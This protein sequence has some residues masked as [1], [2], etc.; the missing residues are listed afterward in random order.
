MDLAPFGTKFLIYFAS[1]VER[2]SGDEGKVVISD[3]EVGEVD[4]GLMRISVIAPEVGTDD[5]REVDVDVFVIA[6]VEIGSGGKAETDVGISVVVGV[7][8]GSDDEAEADVDVFVVIGVER[9]TPVDGLVVAL[10][11]CTVME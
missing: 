9:G 4:S 6:A 10:V 1:P 7:E 2:V 8:V 3:V 5:E 11:V